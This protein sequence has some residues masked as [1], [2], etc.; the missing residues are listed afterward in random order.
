MKTLL[1][2]CLAMGFVFT[3]ASTA[4]ANTRETFDRI[5]T[6]A[7][8]LRRD[9]EDVHR[10]LRD[11]KADLTAVAQ[12][13]AAINTN[14]QALND[15]LAAVDRTDGSLTPAQVAAVDGA[16]TVAMNLVALLKSKTTLLSDTQKAARERSLLRDKAD[17][18]AKRAVMVERHVAPLRG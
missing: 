16:R 9:A 18:V 6:S 5:V 14:A 1:M 3:A 12:R 17:A 7:E 4:A 13:V 2:T 8:S 15:A 11:K 10:M